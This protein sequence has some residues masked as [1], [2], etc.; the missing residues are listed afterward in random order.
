MK[1]RRPLEAGRGFLRQN[2]KKKFNQDG[3]PAQETELLPDMWGIVRV[4]PQE[5]GCDHLGFSVYVH[6]HIDPDT[7][8]ERHSFKVKCRWDH[9]AQ[10]ENGALN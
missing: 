4:P 2:Y 7:G 6:T 5:E 10:A 1:Q 9:K 3:S 8:E